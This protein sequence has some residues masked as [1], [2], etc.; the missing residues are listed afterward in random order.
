MEYASN[1][2]PTSC[3]LLIVFE[4][5][6][7]KQKCPTR[8]FL[9]CEHFFRELL[10]GCFAILKNCLPIRHKL[11]SPSPPSDTSSFWHLTSCPIQKDVRILKIVE[12]FY[13]MI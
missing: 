11:F 10:S 8:F 6:F 2:L 4:R 7:V 12:I 1:W 13:F 3:N 9:S 5:L